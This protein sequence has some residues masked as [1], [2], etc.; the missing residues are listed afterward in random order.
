VLLHPPEGS[1][2]GKVL[3]RSLVGPNTYEAEISTPGHYLQLSS[4]K[5]SSNMPP[6]SPLESAPPEVQEAVEA[7]IDR[8]KWLGGLRP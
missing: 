5:L 8:S 3:V 7:A 2:A 1:D 4:H 6:T